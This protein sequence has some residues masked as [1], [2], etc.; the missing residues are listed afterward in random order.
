MWSIADDSG[1][2][3][4]QGLATIVRDS[5]RERERELINNNVNV[6]CQRISVKRRP[7]WA[8]DDC[9]SLVSAISD[10]VIASTVWNAQC[11]MGGEYSRT[12]IVKTRR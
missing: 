6:Q 2:T 11:M 4:G 1:F 10:T 5:E 9:E 3:M 8:R 7:D 12:W